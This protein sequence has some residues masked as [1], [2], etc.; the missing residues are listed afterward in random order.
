MIIIGGR[1]A[2]NIDAI[3][4]KGF[5]I[6]TVTYGEESSRPIRARLEEGQLKNR[7]KGVPFRLHAALTLDNWII[8]HGGKV[9]NKMRNAEIGKELIAYNSSTS[10][11]Y[12]INIDNQDKLELLRYGHQLGMCFF[13]VKYSRFLIIKR[14]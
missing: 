10:R 6:E 5:D 14:C 4:I 8:L 11:W 2:D 9:F 12:S 3:P 13:H 7:L 1:N